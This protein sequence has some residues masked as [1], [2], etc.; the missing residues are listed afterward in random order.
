[1]LQICK[2]PTLPC[3]KFRQLPLTVAGSNADTEADTNR[4]TATDTNTDTFRLR[5]LRH[6]ADC[7][8][9]LPSA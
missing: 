1:M 2:V 6:V 4:D 3:L 5:L 9:L 7:P 8:F